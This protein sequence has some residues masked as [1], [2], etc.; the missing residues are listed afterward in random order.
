MHWVVDNLQRNTC[1][2]CDQVMLVT[3]YH[4]ATV[5]METLLIRGFLCFVVDQL[6]CRLAIDMYFL[7]KGALIV[8]FADKR[9]LIQRALF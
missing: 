6:E 2:G 9:P 4:R 3:V 1:F 8:G 5:S 7:Y